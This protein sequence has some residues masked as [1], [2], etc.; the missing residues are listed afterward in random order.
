MQG[1]KN[2]GEGGG[3]SPATPRRF[4]RA[5]ESMLKDQTLHG[6]Q[7]ELRHMD[8]TSAFSL[9]MYTRFSTCSS[10]IFI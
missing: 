8:F 10:L 9:W 1:S 5:W 2:L 7:D 4:L 3:A 6:M